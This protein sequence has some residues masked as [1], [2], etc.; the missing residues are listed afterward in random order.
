M[1]R[2]VDWSQGLLRKRADDADGVGTVAMILIGRRGITSLLPE[3][4]I[5]MDDIVVYASSLEEHKEKMNK[6]FGR[7]KTAGLTVRL[8]K[9]FF[10][11][12]EVGYPRAYHIKRWS[13]TR[14]SQGHRGTR[15]PSSKIKVYVESHQ[16]KSLHPEDTPL[17]HF[18]PYL[19]GR[20]F[21]I[22]TDHKPLVWLHNLKN[23][24]SRLARWKEKLRDY[25]YEIIPKPGRVNA[26]TDALSRNPV[27]VSPPTPISQC[28]DDY[29]HEI[30]RRIFA[31]NCLEHVND[32]PEVSNSRIGHRGLAVDELEIS[33][34]RRFAE[35]G[36]YI[37]HQGEA[38]DGQDSDRGAKNGLVRISHWAV[39]SDGLEYH[40]GNFSHSD[41]LVSHRAEPL[42]A[43]GQEG[44]LEEFSYLDGLVSHLAIPSDGP[45]YR[46]RDINNVEVSSEGSDTDD[47][48]ITGISLLPTGQVRK[49]EYVERRNVRVV[50]TKRRRKIPPENNPPTGSLWYSRD[51]LLMHRDNYAHFFSVDCNTNKSLE[52]QLLDLNYLDLELIKTQQLNV[53]AITESGLST[54]HSLF[55]LFIRNNHE[56]IPDIDIICEILTNLGA[57]LIELGQNSISIA[58]SNE[59]L[60]DMYWL[61]IETHLVGLATQMNLNITIYMGEVTTPREE[62]IPGIISEA[63]DSAVAGHKGMIKTY[64]LVRERYFWPNMMDRI[65][66]YVK[67]CHDCQTKK[68]TRVKTKFPMKIKSTPTTALE[69][70]EMDIVGPLPLTVSGNKY[71]LTL[72]CNLTKYS[73]AIPLPDV[74]AGMIASA[75]SNE[76]VC[77]FGCP[78]TLRTDMGQNLI[79]K[80]FSTLAKLF[81][82]R[83]IHSTAYRPQT[84][85]SLE[86]SHHSLIEYRKMY[87]NDSHWDTWIRYAIFSNNTSIHTAH[88]FTPHE[89]IF[90][91]K[92]RIPSEFTTTTISKTYNDILDDI[93]R[94]LNMTQRGAH[95]KIIE[96]KK[97]SK[98]YYDLKSNVRVFNPGDYVYLLKEHKT[99]K[100]DDH[101]TGPYPIKQLIGDRNAEIELSTS[102]SKIV[103]VDKLKHAFLR[104]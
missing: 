67:T 1:Y 77:R 87:I 93:A 22:V 81:K 54:G 13:Q 42:H 26:N 4:F 61:P 16:T 84:E 97:K 86:R 55:S 98:A 95:D 37:C 3:L 33:H 38:A 88:G 69:V 96:A 72:Q 91:R 27:P 50:E 94:K 100:L 24:T 2:G 49:R 18:R 15:L 83:Q 32:R 101:Y 17:Q 82:I 92:A 47:D 19:Y 44:H 89:L 7:L 64:P 9:C 65:R 45:D 78:Q 63:H 35:P 70:V 90:A 104:L 30:E 36:G 10:L 74:K 99:D 53:G 58:K 31:I 60:D 62:D 71:I 23:P 43:D 52:Q 8:D 73:E 79:G 57:A 6:L 20:K 29:E 40:L 51:P 59:H 34:Q 48:M 103:H 11:R 80:V 85:G 46:D 56:E 102:R 5:Y 68:L 39:S 76:F 25:D 41:G 66:N 14:P 75:F 28:I 21:T 12:K